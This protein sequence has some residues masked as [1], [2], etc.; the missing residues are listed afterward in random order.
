MCMGHVTIWFLECVCSSCNWKRGIRQNSCY[1]FRRKFEHWRNSCHKFKQVTL[2]DC[3]SASYLVPT[4][5]E[6]TQEYRIWD[7][8]LGQVNVL[9]IRN[10]HYHLCRWLF[11]FWTRYQGNPEI[12]QG[13]RKEWMQL[14]SL[15]RWWRQHILLIGRKH[16]TGE[17]FQY[18]CPN[19]NWP[20]QQDLGKSWNLIL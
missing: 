17:I 18:A 5:S 16:Q 11:L 4:F 13:D 20:H 7:I 15:I 14:D 3:P 2:W 10:D 19:S 12:H 6:R 8:R 1:V 9:W